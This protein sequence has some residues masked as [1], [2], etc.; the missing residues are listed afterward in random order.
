MQN[1]FLRL[2]QT[3]QVGWGWNV[4]LLGACLKS[5]FLSAQPFRKQPGDGIIG[6]S[7]RSSLQSRRYIFSPM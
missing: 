1:P 5:A 2:R 7:P 4:R 6:Q 3:Y